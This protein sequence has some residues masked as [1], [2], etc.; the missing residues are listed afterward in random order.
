MNTVGSSSTGMPRYH[1][2]GSFAGYIGSAIDVTERRRAAEALATIN[3]RLIDAHEEERSRIARELHDDISQRLA[4]LTMSLD[5]LA[6]TSAASAPDGRQTIE[7]ARDQARTL[8]RDVQ[9][10]SHRLHPAHLE[11]LGIAGAAAALCREI[12]R[13]CAVSRSASAPRASRT[14]CQ[15]GSPGVYTACSRRLCRTPPNTVARG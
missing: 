8:A 14:V 10:V 15:S 6:R 9:A 13:G 1:G 5:A 12:S 2:D 4:L 11:F 7:E 3:Q